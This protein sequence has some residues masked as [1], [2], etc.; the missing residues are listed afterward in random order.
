[1]KP[2][3]IVL[4]L[5]A[6]FGECKAALSHYLNPGIKIGYQFGNNNGFVIGPEISFTAIDDKSLVYFGPVFGISLFPKNFHIISYAEAEFG[7][8]ALGISLGSQ[9]DK[10]LQSRLRIFA[11][12]IGFA[13]FM[14]NLSD[15][16]RECAGVVK[17]P[18][19]KDGKDIQVL[20]Y[21]IG[22]HMM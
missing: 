12:A 9:W 4:S 18:L 20:H 10:G 16:S 2:I 19:L 13:S 22:L 8:K 21:D 7:W 6:L 3:V 11:G 14:V 1:M 15:F 17:V 5:L